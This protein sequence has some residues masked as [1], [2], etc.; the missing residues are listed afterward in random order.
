GLPSLPALVEHSGEPPGAAAEIDDA[1]S[2]RRFDH[3]REIVEWLLPLSLELV[4]LSWAPRVGHVCSSF[5]VASC[6]RRAAIDHRRSRSRNCARRRRADGPAARR[7]LS[8]RADAQ[9]ARSAPPRLEW[10]APY[11]SG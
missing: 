3:R 1:H 8:S 10:A 9:R 2:R 7:R 5:T 6:R 11:G 4:V